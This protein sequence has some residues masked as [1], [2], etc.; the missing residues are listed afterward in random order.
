MTQTDFANGR[1][2]GL[3]VQVIGA[4]RA[5]LGNRCMPIGGDTK[6]RCYRLACERYSETNPTDGDAYDQDQAR[7][8]DSLLHP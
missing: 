8:R 3:F 5:V 2:T 7:R 6:G 4:W 1:T